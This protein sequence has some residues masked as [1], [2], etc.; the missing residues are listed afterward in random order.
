MDEYRQVQ[1]LRELW[2]RS[3]MTWGQVFIPLGAAIVA[4]FAVQSGVGIG[5]PELAL[6]LVGWF[7]LVVCMAYWR[8][9]VH[10]IDS[11]IVSLYP[12]TLRLESELKWEAQ[13]RSYFNHLNGRSREYLRDQ[14]GLERS[15]KAY[16]ELVDEARN[17]SRDH[18]TLLMSVWREYG[19]HSVSP[20]GHRTQDFAILGLV[21]I[22]L[23]AVL[24]CGL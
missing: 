16:E 11:Q 21:L 20:R 22:L 13:S 6:L 8:W 1:R 24:C 2:M 18:Y 19:G 23:A 4:F 15:P 17:Q 7:L 5:E 9:M 3:V 10:H 12:M 14:L